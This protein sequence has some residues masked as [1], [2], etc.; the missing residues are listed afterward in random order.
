[1]LMCAVID[2]AIDGEALVA[3]QHPD[4]KDVGITSVGH[5]L[6]ILKA[7]YEVKIKQNVTVDADHYVPPCKQS[8]H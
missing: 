4:L 1:M 5:R 3:L 8:M 6:T 2:E 7:I